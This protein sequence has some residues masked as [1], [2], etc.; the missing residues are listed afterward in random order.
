MLRRVLHTSDMH[1]ALLD[2]KACRSLEALVD[3]A[4][5]NKVD[6]VVVAGDLFDHNRVS[7]DLVS[8]VVGQFK[9]LPVDVA[10]LP[11]NHDCLVP[12]SVYY[13]D[14]LWRGATNIHIFWSPDGE[15]MNLPHLGVSLWGK[16]IDSYASGV[17]PLSGIPKPEKN[18]HWHIAVAHGY[19]V[20][21]KPLY[22]PSLPILNEEIVTSGWDYIA[23]GHWPVFRCVCDQPVKAYYC[24]S[25]SWAFPRA[26]VN[27]IDFA[28]ETGIQVSRYPL[29]DKPDE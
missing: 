5:A 8:F 18:G 19:Y 26:S 13:R 20:D 23:L 12:D 28:E 9:R 11:G 3:L 17:E 24:D 10:I 15:I 22:L 4:I 29:L 27:I 21:S 2:D 14:E 6:L 7:D 25:P 1:L 16:S